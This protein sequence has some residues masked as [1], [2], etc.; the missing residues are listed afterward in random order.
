MK[1]KEINENKS[2]INNLKQFI[3][4]S[5]SLSKAKT[6]QARLIVNGF[7]QKKENFQPLKNTTSFADIN[8]AN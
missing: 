6:S 4:N 5:I 7:S 3:E 1:Y 2:R 8:V